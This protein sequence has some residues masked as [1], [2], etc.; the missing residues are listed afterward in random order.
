MYSILWTLKRNI[1]C[2]WNTINEDNRIGIPAMSGIWEVVKKKWNKL[3]ENPK[4]EYE[5]M[6]VLKI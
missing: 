1:N 2:M 4:C 3:C 5:R 6:I